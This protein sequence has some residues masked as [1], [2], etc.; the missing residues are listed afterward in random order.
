MTETSD[1]LREQYQD[2][3]DAIEMEGIGYALWPGG[4]IEPITEDAELNEAI[5]KALEGIKTI[6]RIMEPYSC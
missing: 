1:N 6:E 3:A 4:Y 5:T 2:I